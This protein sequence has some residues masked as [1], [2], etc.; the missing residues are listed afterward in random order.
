MYY[1]RAVR[2]L[3]NCEKWQKETTRGIDGGGEGEV[4]EPQTAGL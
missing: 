3:Q 2:N 4:V 1:M